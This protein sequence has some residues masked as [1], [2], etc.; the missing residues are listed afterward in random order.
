MT[1]EDTDKFIALAVAVIICLGSLIYIPDFNAIGICSENQGWIARISYSFFH[2]SF[3]HALINAYCLLQLAFFIGINRYQ[4]MVSFVIAS[5]VPSFIL[6]DIPTVGLSCACYALLGIVSPKIDM[7][8]EWMFWISVYLILGFFL[9]QVNGIMH[10]YGYLAGLMVGL[11]T[12]PL[13]WIRR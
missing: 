10:L 8:M 3:F 12:T 13:K 5:L 2:T 9:P 11:L 4:M 6:S 1:K 7:R